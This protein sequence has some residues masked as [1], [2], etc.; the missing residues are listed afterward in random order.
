VGGGGRKRGRNVGKWHVRGGGGA[1]LC[2]RKPL[3]KAGL[4]AGGTGGQGGSVSGEG[5]QGKLII[6]GLNHP[7]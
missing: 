7:G 4:N 1:I 3:N 5:H 2:W 6:V